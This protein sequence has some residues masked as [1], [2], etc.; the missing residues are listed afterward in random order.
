MTTAAEIIG[1]ALQE[2]VVQAA[3]API[4]ASEAAY[5]IRAMNRFMFKL[6][7]DG[8]ALG[9]TVVS[10]LADLITIPPGAEQGLVMNL[11]LIISGQFGTVPS[12]DTRVAAKQGMETMLKLADLIPTGSYPSTLPIG[13]GNEGRH[14]HA[15]R[16]FYA[17][18]E[19]QILA[20]TTG[21]I[22]LETGTDEA[23]GD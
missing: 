20:E 7:A 19:E 18:S 21:A 9:Y 3:E 14:N 15:N 13:S 5:A 8:V 10:G 11:A 23:A 16:H 1:D 22:G 4:E 6:D 2:L 17:G 12:A